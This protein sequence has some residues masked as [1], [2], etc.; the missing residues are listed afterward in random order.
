MH[1]G[2]KVSCSKCYKTYATNSALKNHLDAIHGRA[3]YM[4][5][6]CGMTFNQKGNMERHVRLIHA[7]DATSEV[8]DNEQILTG[9]S[10]N[11]DEIEIEILPIY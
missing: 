11:Q 9:S 1:D 8:N 4:C 2:V 5:P 7:T 10:G 6:S 3:G